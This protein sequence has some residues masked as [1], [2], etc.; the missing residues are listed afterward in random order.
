MRKRVF[1]EWHS[2]MGLTAGLM[3]FVICWSGTIAVFAYEIDWLLDPSIRS[4]T[5]AGE[6]EWAAVA[7]AAGDTY[8][9]ER[10]SW[11]AAPRYPGFAAVAMLENPH[12]GLRRVYIDAASHELLGATS[13]LNVQRFFRSLHMAL[14]QADYFSVLGIPVGYFAVLLF[15]FPLLGMLVTS[16]VFYRRWWRGFAKLETR[17]GARTFWSDAHKL[18]GVWSLPLVAIICLTSFWYLAEWWLPRA[19][20]ASTVPAAAADLIGLDRAVQLARDAFPGLDIRTV[21]PP[22]G[23]DA[24][25]LVL[26]HD[27]GMLTRGRASVEID[28]A[29]GAVV[30]MVGT[31][32][33]GVV[34][35]IKEA[36]DLL[37]FG[38]FGGLW[39][40]GVYFI[41]GLALSGLALSGAYL[42]AGRR[43]RGSARR[44]VYGRREIIAAYVLTL[45]LLAL[46]FKAGFDEIS[47]YAAHAAWPDTPLGVTLFLATWIAFTLAVLTT[48]CWKLR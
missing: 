6:L 25:Y 13:F 19:D 47:A 3:L 18:C 43:G 1:F 21:I 33:L 2:V 17:Q 42:H 39:T 45:L 46:T 29:T 26:G 48:W 38:T 9:G 11:I 12:G 5:P 22:G 44:S 23:D 10:I 41:L 7:D 28:K 14:F 32:D 36:V 15:A 37:H 27:G 31:A 40:Q 4:E 34:D 24:A 20:R 35:R 8:P 16:L 30:S